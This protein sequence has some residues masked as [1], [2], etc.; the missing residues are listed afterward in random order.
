MKTYISTALAIAYY[1]YCSV[2]F[3]IDDPEALLTS[4]NVEFQKE[5]IQVAPNVYTAVGC[6]VSTTSMIIGENGLVIID[7]QIDPPA[8]NAV[9]AEFRKITDVPVK[10][11]ILTHGHGDH[12]GGVQVFAAAGE[13]VQIWARQGFN[14]ES[15]DLAEAGL[16]IQ[17]QRGA[18]QG[19]VPARP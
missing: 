15:R 6:G 9:L 2:S 4:R 13:D 18:R 16:T 10:G 17:K 19:G 12:T 8:A 7:T 5:I 1:V 11:I 14:Q 3:A